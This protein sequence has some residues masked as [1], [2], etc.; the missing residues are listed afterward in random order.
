MGEGRSGMWCGFGC[1]LRASCFCR[2]VKAV[3]CVLCL[4]LTSGTDLPKFLIALKKYSFSQYT[5]RLF[6]IIDCVVL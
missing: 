1:L 4:Q 2:L 5:D 3:G 6:N